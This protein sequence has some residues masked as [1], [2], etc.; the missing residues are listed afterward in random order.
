M[1]DILSSLIQRD[2]LT[3]EEELNLKRSKHL[4]VQWLVGGN[5]RSVPKEAKPFLEAHPEEAKAL[6]DHYR[7]RARKKQKVKMNLFL[8]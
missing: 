6:F 2:T 5:R 7:Q 8:I 1:M 3:L 4:F